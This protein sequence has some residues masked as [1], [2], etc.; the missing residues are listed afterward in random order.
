MA[1]V[2]MLFY[3]A[4]WKSEDKERTLRKSCFVVWLIYVDHYFGNMKC[5]WWVFLSTNFRRSNTQRYATDI[6]VCLSF[7]SV[8]EMDVASP[9]PETLPT[10]CLTHRKPLTTKKLLTEANSVINDVVKRTNK[11]CSQTMNSRIFMTLL[12]YHKSDF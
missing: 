7:P 8:K 1:W 6:A 4:S 10:Q 12:Q 3:F 9:P 5:S 11:I 2:T